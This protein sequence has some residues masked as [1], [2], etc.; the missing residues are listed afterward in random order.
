[1]V[2]AEFTREPDFGALVELLQIHFDQVSYGRQGDDWIWVEE[3]DC[4]VEIDTFW[5]MQLQIKT[6][7]ADCTLIKR[8]LDLIETKFPVQRFS[9]PSL[10]PH[11]D[12]NE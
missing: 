7:S 10:E 2:Y 11:E 1:M 12:P 4:K 3:D 8:V 9:E 5:S 6:A